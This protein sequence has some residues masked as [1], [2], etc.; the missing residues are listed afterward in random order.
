M[1]Q[2]R[3]R[4][5]LSRNEP[6]ILYFD[7]TATGLN[8]ILTQLYYLT[9]FGDKQTNKNNDTN[10]HIGGTALAWRRSI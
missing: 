5:L 1:F 8:L 3:A 6:I 9:F 2:W 7:D 10:T 4:A